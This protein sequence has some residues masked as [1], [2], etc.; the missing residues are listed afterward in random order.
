M[1]KFDYSRDE[2]GN[3]LLYLANKA[4]I[5]KTKKLEDWLSVDYDKEGN[6]VAIEIL[7]DGLAK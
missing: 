7:N 6:I 3:T 5:V 4:I 2:V 1:K